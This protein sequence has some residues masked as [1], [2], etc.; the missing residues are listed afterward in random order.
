MLIYFF[1][2]YAQSN[3]AET[4][5]VKKIES[6]RV[7]KWKVENAS[8]Y[9]GILTGVDNSILLDFIENYT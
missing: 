9:Q 4:I 1:I 2:L 3:E 6:V 7:G 8:C 5:F